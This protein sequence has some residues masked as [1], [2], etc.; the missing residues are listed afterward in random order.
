[1]DEILHDK[2]FGEMLRRILA[3]VKQNDGQA[4]QK[5]KMVESWPK[6]F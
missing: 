2:H 1:M 5:L 4:S 3:A 6:D